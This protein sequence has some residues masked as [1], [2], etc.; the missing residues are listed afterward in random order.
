VLKKTPLL[1][2]REEEAVADH[3]VIRFE[4][5]LPAW[6]REAIARLGFGSLNK[7]VLYFDKIFWDPNRSMF[8]RLND[9]S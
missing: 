1:S 7:I 5:P 4:P 2:S 9:T 3:A 8:G 6:K